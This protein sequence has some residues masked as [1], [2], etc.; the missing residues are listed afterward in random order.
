MQEDGCGPGAAERGDDFARDVARFPDAGDDDFPGMRQDQVDG[1][2]EFAIQPTGRALVR[3]AASISMAARATA[4]HS[5]LGNP[6]GSSIIAWRQR[7]NGRLCSHESGVFWP[8]RCYRCAPSAGWRSRSLTILHTNDV[9]AHL[10]PLDDHTGGFAYLAATIRHEREG[11]VGCILL[12]AGDLVQGTPV[13]TL[14]H[15]LPVYE[16]AT[17]FGYNAG[18]LGN[19]EFD[20][21]WMQARKFVQMAKYP[22]VTANLVN[23]AGKLFTPKPYVI[24]RVNHLRVAVIGGITDE[25][26]SLTNP[27]IMGD[28]HTTPVVATVRKYVAEVRG[29]VDLI[30]LL[31]HID[32]REENEFLESVPE[33]GVCITGHIHDGIDGGKVEQWA[34]AGA[35]EILWRHA[36]QARSSGGHQA[37]KGGQLELAAGSGGRED[38]SGGRCGGAGRQVGRGGAGT[39]GSADRGVRSGHSSRTRNE[40]RDGSGHCV[41]RRARDFNVFMNAGSARIGLPKGQLLERHIWDVM[42]F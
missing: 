2:D 40:G 33:I 20:Y 34:G 18:T 12:N 28:W 32:E 37:T 6:C 39:G 36:R 23:Q 5:C 21:G 41:K 14:F 25:L 27:K 15:G 30:V 3:E 4:S 7:Y 9:H 11:C 1:A 42:P 17:L 29:K 35:D 22:V 31:A 8:S 19:H 10:L 38:R 24:L 13:S 26:G 16:I